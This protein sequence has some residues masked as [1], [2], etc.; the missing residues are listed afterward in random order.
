VGVGTVDEGVYRDGKWIPDAGSMVTKTIRAGPGVSVPGRSRLNAARPI[1]I[2]RADEMKERYL[3]LLA[4][5]AHAL[6]L[7]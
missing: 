3:A 5:A 7:V 6:G 1:A 4:K 2:N